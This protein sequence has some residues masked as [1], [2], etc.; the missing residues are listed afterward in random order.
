MSLA[1]YLIPLSF[2]FAGI[3]QVM[4]CAQPSAQEPLTL[5]HA[6]AAAN[7]NARSTIR[8]HRYPHQVCLTSTMPR[9]ISRLLN[10]LLKTDSC[11]PSLSLTLHEMMMYIKREKQVPKQ[12]QLNVE[13]CA[14]LKGE[15]ANCKY[16][17]IFGK[18]L[19]LQL[20][21]TCCNVS[22]FKCNDDMYAKQKIEQAKIQQSTV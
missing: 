22:Y 21:V 16:C 2:A 11:A 14:R 12:Q 9:I 18:M 3:I 15:C 5:S 19:S 1:R 6:A 10:C 20:L 4:W 8:D 13:E 7:A 17:F